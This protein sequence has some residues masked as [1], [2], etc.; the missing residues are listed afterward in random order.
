MISALEPPPARPAWQLNCC[1]AEIDQRLVL[2]KGT[3]AD[4]CQ[5]ADRR[6]FSQRLSIQFDWVEAI[7]IVPLLNAGELE[8]IVRVVW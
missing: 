6:D 8:A 7:W 4:P 3:F 5:T 1:E 2:A